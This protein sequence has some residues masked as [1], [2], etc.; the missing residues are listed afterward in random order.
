MTAGVPLLRATPAYAH[1]LAAIHAASFPPTEQWGADVM[2]LQLGLPGAFGLMH[3]GSAMI[4]A[5]CVA[6][7]SEILVVAVMPER[8]RDGLGRTLLCAAMEEAGRQGARCM[9]L[10][11]AVRNIAARALYAQA[12]FTQVGQRSRYYPDGGDALVLRAELARS[13]ERSG[14]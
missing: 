10:E 2:A 5:R 13:Q 1:E 7:E 6:D 11:V 3:I 8:R 14:P 4:L 9:F 12:G